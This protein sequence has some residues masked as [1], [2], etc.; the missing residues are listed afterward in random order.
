MA[1][2]SFGNFS[3]NPQRKGAKNALICD[4]ILYSK[5]SICQDRLGTNIGK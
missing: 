2:V 3:V 4:A 5:P 1:F